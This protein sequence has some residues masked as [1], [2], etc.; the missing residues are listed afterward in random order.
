MK[1]SEYSSNSV[2]KKFNYPLDN[3]EG[4]ILSGRTCRPSKKHR[5]KKDRARED[6]R[7]SKQ[8]EDDSNKEKAKTNA[9]KK[10]SSPQR[11]AP[12]L[13]WHLWKRTI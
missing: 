2:E 4:D 8:G 9:S 7:N 11:G 3:L 10:Q 6:E 1:D 5:P 13:C 12:V